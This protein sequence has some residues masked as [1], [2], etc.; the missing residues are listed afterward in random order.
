MINTD[1]IKNNLKTSLFGKYIYYFPEIDSTN[2]YAHR[3]AHEGAPEGTVVLTDYQ[4]QGKGRLGRDWKSPKND[5]I[6]MSIILRPQL[7]IEQV[8]KISLASA[9]IIVETLER[10]LRRSKINALDF[11][12]KWPNDIMVKGKKIAGILAESSLREKDIVFVIVGIGININQDLS[13]L[14]EEIREKATSLYIETSQKYDRE[15]IISDLIN[16]YEKT[17][18]N[19][20]RTNYNLVVK[21]WK[22]R[23]NHIGN[24]MRIKTHS[25]TES[26][27]FLDVDERGILLYQTADGEVK[28]LISGT[29]KSIKAIHGSDD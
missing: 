21:E 26:G 29:I 22:Q 24:Q 27:K 15:E 9:G 3:L 23:C 4:T 14:D 17:Y 25:T 11:N 13:S 16:T 5:G 8:I 18:I 7:S 28:Q 2:A 1:Q 10:F 19:L 20:E 12:L 6:L